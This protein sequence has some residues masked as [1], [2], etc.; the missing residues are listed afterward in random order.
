[1]SSPEARPRRI[2]RR[3]SLRSRLL[4]LAA[5]SCAGAWISGGAAIYFVV[6]RADAGLF[7]AR[8]ND[9]A[10]TLLVF[11]A[12]ELR[13][14]AREGRALPAHFDTEGSRQGRHRYQIWSREGRLLLSSDSAADRV[15]LMPPGGQGFA[16]RHIGNQ[17]FRVVELS[18][19]SGA[20][21][22]QAAE[23]VDSRLEISGLFG[24]TLVAGLVLSALALA[25]LC[26][27]WLRLALRPVQAA[28]RQIAER[29]PA[30]LRAVESHDLPDELAPVLE[31]INQFMHR[32]DVALRSEREFVA[33]AAHELRTP[34]AGVRAQAQL[35]A[36]PRTG[37][38]ARGLALQAVQDGVDHAAHLVSQLLDLAR[39]DALA[40]D[41]ARL[42][43]DRRSVSI[44]AVFEGVMSDVGPAAAERGLRLSQHFGE[45]LLS[46]S[47]FAVG[48]IL[49][50]LLD[51]AIAHAPSGGEVAVG[52][53]AQHN[54]C[55]LWVE[56]S[57][58]G[59]SAA[60]RGRVCERFYR[61]RG[62]ER[63][64]CGL[65]LSIVKSLA[66]AHGATLVLGSSHLGGLRVEIG[67]PSP[68]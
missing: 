25:V 12:H 58:P 11:A 21:R 46:G 36:H 59:I 35:A 7:D 5:A 13:E 23:P 48:L 52:S 42:L 45:P 47:D 64:G 62:T 61:I 20:Y 53:R 9:L 30:D 10:Q 15:P 22:I 68:A 54:R 50:N 4:A 34:M 49:R 18:A 1:V 55:V 3:W 29:G 37:A 28:A 56:D 26:L 60:E 39:S 16:T 33:A 51:N 31:A 38:K 27:L 40:G 44:A 2:G 24:G 67:F 6:Q 19:P 57:G 32:I 41:P 14:A 65:G 8:L 66:D 63:P 17:A 43:E